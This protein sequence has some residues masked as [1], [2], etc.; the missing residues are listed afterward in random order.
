LISGRIVEWLTTEAE[1]LRQ[2]GPELAAHQVEQA[3]QRAV[4]AQEFMLGRSAQGGRTAAA[5]EIARNAAYATW[6]K[7]MGAMGIQ[8]SLQVRPLGFNFGVVGAT[9]KAKSTIQVQNRGQGYLA[10][11]VE[12]HMPWLTIPNPAFG[13][14]AGETAQV[15]VEVRG[16]NLQTGESYSP[17]AIHVLSN[18]GET[19]L[20]ARAAS[21]P[22]ILS[23]RPQTLNFGP[24]TRGA[25]RITQLNVSNRGGG[26]LSGQVLS[27]A[28]YLRVRYPD[29]SCP[30]G[31]SAQIDVELLSDRLP[32]GAVRIRRALAVDSDS[33]QARIDVAWKWARPALE[34]DTTGLDMGSVQRGE[35]IQRTLTLSNSGTAALT[36]ITQSQVDWLT[37]QPTKLDC[38]PGTSQTIVVTCDTQHLPGGS[39][40]EAEALVIKANAG[41]QVLSASI[42]V[43]AA[44]LVV[45]PREID[46]GVVSDEEQAEETLVIGN[47]G[48]LPWVGRIR[49]TVPWLAVEPDEIRCEPGHF[50][51]VSVML[52]TEALEAGGDWLV[53]DAILIGERDQ[54]LAT[55][56]HVALSRPQLEIAR[57]S[58][59][60]GLIGRT[61][62]ETLP[63]EITNS[64][65]GQL[66]WR[67]E[68][69]GTWLEAVPVQ[70]TCGAGETVTVNINA[71][72]LAVD[73]ASARA[74][75]TVH[76][77]GGRIDMPASV[78]LSSPTLSVEPLFV[79][80]ESENYAEVVQ[81]I[82]LSNRGVGTLSGTITSQVPWLIC[83]PERFECATGAATQ[84]K[85][86]THMDGLDPYERV[87]GTQEITDALIVKS[88]AGDQEIGAR[89]SLLL[90]PQLHLTPQALEF[91]DDAETATF[92]LENQGYGTLRVHLAPDK[93]WI[94]VNRQEWTVKAQKRAR[95]RVRLL[96]APESGQGSIQIQTPDTVMLLPV[97]KKS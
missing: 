66:E 60:F 3:A 6:L 54:Q 90:T 41:T 71:Y 44:H 28:P 38:A 61:E 53:P 84:I 80:L 20:E 48:S 12:S 45:E 69:R 92:Q 51:P 83:E 18:G 13:C 36:G 74:W 11:R 89:L 7:N 57:H 82:R 95:V 77:N 70:G 50:S 59:D 93:P 17:Q 31:A 32:R 22:P 79:E 42:E 34:L 96:D 55:S 29:F 58:L 21:S 4:Q 40:V 39:T 49:T 35:R 1:K 72:A 67:I 33:G 43:L 5:Q 97:E 30:A 76:S 52:Q 78:A 15:Q 65:T 91:I 75:L 27:Q 63:L 24:I 8:P 81:T 23:V 85:V 9:V 37:V 47:R 88:N 26:R 16:R 62:I 87:H 68:T 73:G 19:W 2:T 46:L 25:S 56:V 64:G 86:R 10:G 14:R 94:T